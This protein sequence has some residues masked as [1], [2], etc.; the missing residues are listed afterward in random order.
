M[1]RFAE[2]LAVEE[3]VEIQRRWEKEQLLVRAIEAHGERLKREAEKAR[4]E[5]EELLR[6]EADECERLEGKNEEEELRTLKAEESERLEGK[7]EEEELLR[8]EVE[9]ERLRVE[10]EARWHQRLA[11]HAREQREA[12]E[13]A[14]L[15]EHARLE[16]LT[17]EA[18]ERER[19]RLEAEREQV[20]RC[21]QMQAM[22]RRRVTMHVFEEECRVVRCVQMQAML[23]RRVA[24]HVFDEECRQR[25]AVEYEKVR[26]HREAVAREYKIQS[27]LKKEFPKRLQ[28]RI[29]ELMVL[30]KNKG[31]SFAELEDRLREELLAE[32]TA[33][34]E[35]EEA[36]PPPMPMQSI[37]YPNGPDP[38]RPNAK[39]K[40]PLGTPRALRL[41]SL[42]TGP[43]LGDNFGQQSDRSNPWSDRSHAKTA[44]ARPASLLPL[45]VSTPRST[46]RAGGS[47]RATA[48]PSSP[49]MR[50]I[51]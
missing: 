22:L 6:L 19:D 33:Q 7:N 32:I 14:R 15:A 3:K 11:A 49:T 4:N 47:A 13:Q 20:M 44:D 23:R 30:P 42:L 21:A 43:Q 27:T 35:G 40:A 8:P 2:E 51:S 48:A 36:E 37:P 12:E 50:S 24:M 5:E 41:G 28:S 18:E 39:P 17:L 31:V 25:V 38:K 9:E 29:V 1:H 45:P 46:M 34:I 10:E 26:A 16:Q